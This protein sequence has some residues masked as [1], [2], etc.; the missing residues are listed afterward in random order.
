[1]YRVLLKT[2]MAD[3]NL[4]YLAK[5][6]FFCIKRYLRGSLLLCLIITFHY[7]CSS[8]IKVLQ[9]FPKSFINFG[10]NMEVRNV[11]HVYTDF[12]NSRLFSNFPMVVRLVSVRIGINLPPLLNLN[13]LL[14]SVTGT[15]H[16]SN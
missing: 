11:T 12:F 2:K 10:A 8:Q 9:N 5:C 13:N 6:G 15:N 14:V 1:M 16:I 3:A 7:F 4:R